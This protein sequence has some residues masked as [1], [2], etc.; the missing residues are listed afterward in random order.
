MSVQTYQHHAEA[1]TG[2]G[3]R[4]KLNFEVDLG[5]STSLSLGEY[6]GLLWRSA[7]VIDGRKAFHDDAPNS[8]YI[9]GITSG[10]QVVFDGGGKSMGFLAEG[11]GTFDF[12]SVQ[13]TAAWSQDLT[14][15]ITGYLDG[16][17][18]YSTKIHITDDAPTLVKLN[19]KG[20]DEVEMSPSKGVADPDQPH[21]GNHFVM[22]DLVI[23]NLTSA[24]PV[25]QTIFNHAFAGDTFAPA[26]DALAFAHSQH[27]IAQ[28][29]ALV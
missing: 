6:G 8:G 28:I 17:E 13:M 9:T 1:I 23:A 24:T 11:A 14:V 20:V 16:V 3:T 5:G 15:K 2:A 21:T 27:A 7:A 22:D 18:K 26:H 10:R 29:T 25:S 19:W 4:S 12:K